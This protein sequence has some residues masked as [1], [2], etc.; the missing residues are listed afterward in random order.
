MQ[1]QGEE[2]LLSPLY[3][4]SPEEKSDATEGS[5]SVSKLCVSRICTF[6]LVPVRRFV[7]DVYERVVGARDELVEIEGHT[8]MHVSLGIS[9]VS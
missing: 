9:E 1:A 3:A 4:V 8:E 5:V 2:P 7:Q 6:L